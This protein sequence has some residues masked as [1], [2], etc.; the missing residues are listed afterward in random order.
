MGNAYTLSIETLLKQLEVD[1]LIGLS[2][3]EVNKR[4]KKYG[5]NILEVKKAKSWAL[6]L[7]NQFLNPI[8]YILVAATILAFSFQEW[9]EGIAVI[10]VILLNSGIGFA[11]ELKATRMI[12]SL[13]NSAQLLSTVLREGKIVSITAASLV[14]GD[15]L[16][17]SP[18][19]IIGADAR[20][21]HQEGIAVTE[22]A[23]TGESNQVAKSKK[24]LNLDTPVYKRSNMLYKGTIVNKG[25]AKAIVTATG[26]HTELGS[27][28]K[29]VQEAVKED[30]PLGK[31][32]NS[33]SHWLII[34]TIFLTLVIIVIGYLEGREW[35]ILIKTSIA[36]AVAAIPEGLPIVATITLAHGMV[37]LSKQKVIIKRLE[38]VQTLGEITM[39]CTD[40]TGT[41]TLNEMKVSQVKLQD[42]VI[43]ASSLN[44]NEN[45]EAYKN[46]EPSFLKF[47]EVSILCNNAFIQKENSNG[48]SLEI[49]LLAFAEEL[50][51]NIQDVKL[52]YPEVNEIPFDEN[53]KFMATL[54]KY[55]DSFQICVKGALETLLTKCS[56]RLDENGNK[57]ELDRNRWL[58]SSEEIASQGLRV[59]GFAYKET[60]EAI[61]EGQLHD[62]IFIGIVGFLDPPRVDVGQA[63]EIYRKAGIKVVMITGD[64]LATAQKI[65]EEI[66]L[67]VPGED[68]EKKVIHGSM[69]KDLKNADSAFK[70]MLL[71]ANVF[72]RII[73]EQKL[74][75]VEFFQKNNQVVGMMG[76]GINDTPALRKADIGIA[77]GIRG[78]DAAKDVADV[79]LLDDKFA[80][81]ELTIR[82][83]RT[84][85]RNIRQFVVY[86]LSC[87]LA[88]IL[89]VVIAS[90]INIP[91]PLLPLQILFLN[92][93]TDTFPALALGMGKGK[94][95]IM[96]RPPR[97]PKEQIITPLLW[98]SIIVYGLCVTFIVTGV[99]LYTHFILKL[100]SSVV[101]NIS[102]YTL[103]WVQ[104]LH[105]FNIPSRIHSFFNNEVMHNKWVWGAILLSLF[106]VFIAYLIPVIRTALSLLPLTIGQYL[107][108]FF[109]GLAAIVLIQILKRIGITE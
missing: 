60:E 106:L 55:G 91:L 35:E 31:R 88:E 43:M 79:I 96:E 71:H 38:A 89:S 27:I 5:F 36:L 104:L 24:A 102:F 65:A 69:I 83:G 19:T 80:S 105:V 81:T 64:H 57:I 42:E 95:V 63:I 76:D 59:L 73:P 4:A 103:V 6:I 30:T 10:I 41:L 47:I 85:F 8:I 40:K 99:T 46:S 26:A 37:K 87:N 49:A 97:D 7:L 15:V 25:N 51:H 29:L 82:Q 56:Y 74:Q 52:K 67:L 16:I 48:D 28:N 68:N 34:L 32:L 62:L 101:N 22:S 77:M 23:L 9:L 45:G 20:I 92:L 12:E 66:N 98:R 107:I 86:L 50:G 84:I 93:V 108:V 2:E 109:A 54:N 21:I 17:L 94:K 13:Q 75:L 61:L 33:L 70:S 3:Q 53:T 90:I 58:Q 11:M 100:P 72:A 1:P 18:G 39:M 14:P 44:L 78:T